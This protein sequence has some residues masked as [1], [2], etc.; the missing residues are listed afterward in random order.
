[1][2]GSRD[3]VSASPGQSN[4]NE[5]TAFLALAVALSLLTVFAI[6]SVDYL[7]TSD[8]PERIFAGAMLNHLHDTGRGY[9]RFLT[10]NPTLTD[11]GFEFAFARFEPWWGWRTAYQ[12]V[13]C[14]LALLWAWGVVALAA[15]FGPQ[16]RWWGLLGFG[17]ALQW[18]F[19]MGQ[20]S[21]EM[22]TALGFLVLAWAFRR[23]AR[24][25]I[26]RV[27]LAALL[28]LQAM[29]H[30]FTAILT[31]CV[32]LIHGVLAAPPKQR[33][34]ALG[35]LVASGLPAASIALLTLLQHLA[36]A[37][38]ARVNYPPTPLW[39]R[40]VL[41]G[42]GFVS[43]PWWRA[44][45]LVALAAW[46]L[47]RCLRGRGRG[48]DARERSLAI[49]GLGLTACAV[50]LPLHTHSWEFFCVRFTPFGVVFLSMLV[51]PVVAPRPARLLVVAA[52]AVYSTSALLWSWHHHRRIRAASADLVAAFS[53]PLERH[54]LRLPLPLEPPPG[55]DPDEWRRDIPYVTT[56]GHMGALF[57]IEQGGVP[58]VSF[59]GLTGQLQRWR[60]PPETWMP[61]RPARGFEWQ[62]WEPAVEADPQLRAAGLNHY[63]SYAAPY[64]DVI[65]HLRARDADV[66]RQRGF[67]ID[68][69]QG[70]F[71]IARFRG[72]A[73][74]VTVPALPDGPVP[75]L[76]TAG[77]APSRRATFASVIPAGEAA[78]TLR[79]AGS[80]CGNTWVRI[81]YDMD[82]NG[83]PSRGDRTCL[84]AVADGYLFH[85][86]E[87]WDGGDH[88]VCEPGPPLLAPEATTP[89]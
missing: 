1:M 85:R 18:S 58:A 10:A 52:I 88:L 81:L 21:S 37:G 64:E 7:A 24:S 16:R 3:P 23:P 61:P 47:S 60:E 67:V 65:L 40:L 69:Q 80:P 11:L 82:G 72:C 57:A 50:L 29:V 34:R 42:R 2:A 89:P 48:L 74:S 73:F 39:Q 27:G 71:M 26:D 5:T 46:G 76:V 54:G 31:G 22:G 66:L 17:S 59:A 13:L 44:W 8:G 32:L 15:C 9:D 12:V 20:Y 83:A 25:R 28:L 43:G 63:L 41:L 49:A 78:R 79:I 51:A 87:P 19:Y 68:F 55:E 4:H 14:L 86:V 36:N 77:W 45:P 56:D 30:A 70:D 53:A 6:T 62:L 33:V 38:A 84:G 75:A 35:G